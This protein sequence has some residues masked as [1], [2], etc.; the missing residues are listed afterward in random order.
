MHLAPRLPSFAAHA[1]TRARAGLAF[2]GSVSS[3][4]EIL[5]MGEGSNLFDEARRRS[6]KLHAFLKEEN[7]EDY[8]NF[9]S[10]NAHTSARLQ[11]LSVCPASGTRI[12][13]HSEP[14]ALS[15]AA[16]FRDWSGTVL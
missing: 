15:A 14:A 10:K 12:R 16:S 9:S 6:R 8:F 3:A 2:F 11:R 5:G 13:V 1:A 4:G 7:P